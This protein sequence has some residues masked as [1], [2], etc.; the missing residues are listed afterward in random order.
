MKDAAE[1]RYHFIDDHGMCRTR[2]N[3]AVEHTTTLGG[4]RKRSNSTAQLEWVDSLTVQESPDATKPR[5]R[6]TK[7][8]QEASP[9]ICPKLLGSPLGQTL[10]KAAY[11][12]SGIEELWI[13]PLHQRQ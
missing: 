11:E 13:R 7:S 4:K 2:L 5:R 8:P 10:G 9:T 1:M 12:A 3:V 6:L